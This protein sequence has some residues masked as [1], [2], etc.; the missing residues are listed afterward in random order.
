MMLADGAL[1]P[2]VEINARESMGIIANSICGFLASHGVSGVLTSMTISSTQVP[3]YGELLEALTD[4]GILWLPGKSK[5]MIPL[6]STSLYVTH[7]DSSGNLSKSRWYAMLLGATAAEQ[8]AIRD[9][10]LSLCTDTLRWQ[11]L[12]SPYTHKEGA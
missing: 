10:W 3:P 7:N 6:T 12:E 9:Q 8:T 1:W 5:G 4:A 2:V 11:I